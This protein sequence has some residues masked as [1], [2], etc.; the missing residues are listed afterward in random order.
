MWG[1][2]SGPGPGDGLLP[3]PLAC[4]E[5]LCASAAKPS[6]SARVRAGVRLPPIHSSVF[7]ESGNQPLLCARVTCSGHAPA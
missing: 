6:L 3:C 7:V 2:P 4:R 1:G 5:R